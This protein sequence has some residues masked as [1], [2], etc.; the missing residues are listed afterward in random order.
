MNGIESVAQMSP[1][2]SPQ[3]GFTD[4]E[5]AHRTSRAQ[6]LMQQQGVDLLLLMTE[7]EVR[8][9][10]GFLTQFW[11]SPTRPWFLLLPQ[12]GKPVAVIP[13]IGIECMSR[14]WLE[15]IRTWSSPHQ[16]DD[17]VGL[18]VD[19]ITTLVGSDPTVGLPMGKES[20]LRMPL[21]D[22]ARLQNKLP[23][24][25][26]CNATDLIQSLRQIKSETE[27]DKIRY[28]AQTV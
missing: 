18:L 8:Y 10:S 11:Q 15:D 16:N 24:A 25:Q 9:F 19:T 28:T 3:R 6:N 14:T 26:W 17:G 21:T 23:R 1:L 5:F 12:T 4:E 7:P 13:S 22:Y 2:P 20:S 27:I